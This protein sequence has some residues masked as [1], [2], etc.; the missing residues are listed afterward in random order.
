MGRRIFCIYVYVC[1]S[2]EEYKYIQRLTLCVVSMEHSLI[3]LWT[4]FLIDLELTF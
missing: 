2:V 3:Y 4:K 1:K